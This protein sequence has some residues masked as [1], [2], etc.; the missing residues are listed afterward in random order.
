MLVGKL[1]DV[2]EGGVGVETFV[3]LTEGAVVG[4]SGDLHQ[5][6]LGLRI[7]G[8]VRVTYSTEIFPGLYRNGLQFVEVAYARAS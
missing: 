5:K 7:S 6:E 8:R 2:S 3:P 4:V 1:V